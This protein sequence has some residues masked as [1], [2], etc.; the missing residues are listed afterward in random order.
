MG[1]QCTILAPLPLY[2]LWTSGLLPFL[3]ITNKAIIS[4]L[5]CISCIIYVQEFLRAELLREW[6]ADHWCPN[7][8]CFTWDK[9]LR[10]GCLETTLL[11]PLCVVQ[12]ACFQS[13]TLA[14]EQLIHIVAKPLISWEEHWVPSAFF[15]HLH[16]STS[17]SSL[18][19]QWRH[20]P[21]C[22]TKPNQKSQA[23]RGIWGRHIV[24]R[25]I[26]LFPLQLR[27]QVSMVLLGVCHDPISDPTPGLPKP[28]LPAVSTADI[29]QSAMWHHEEGCFTTS[30][31]NPHTCGR[32]NNKTTKPQEEFS[33]AAGTAGDMFDEKKR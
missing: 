27:Y 31:Y 30:K 5:V 24:V 9:E 12:L 2:Y 18:F 3:V 11:S 23:N 8:R 4:T 26:S 1:F 32:E 10:P 13:R 25:V 22:N 33:T 29:T 21:Q 28:T 20:W 19:N 7:C 14:K 16:L 15:L 6:S 17:S